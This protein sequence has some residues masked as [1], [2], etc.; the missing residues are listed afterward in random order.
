MLKIE[1][2]LTK[3]EDKTIMANCYEDHDGHK[4]PIPGYGFKSGDANSAEDLKR[5]LSANYPG[6]PVYVTSADGSVFEFSD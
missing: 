6:V 5:K 3:N 4:I 1:V 2:F